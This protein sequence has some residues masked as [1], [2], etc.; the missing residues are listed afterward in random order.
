MHGKINDTPLQIT[1]A[2]FFFLQLCDIVQCWHC[3][4]KLRAWERDNDPWIECGK[5][6]PECQFVL[7]E[8]CAEFIHRLV[9][10]YPDPPCSK[11][12]MLKE[13]IYCNSSI[14]AAPP[15]FLMWRLI[16]FTQS[17]GLILFFFVYYM[18]IYLFGFNDFP[19]LFK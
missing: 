6:F 11:I 1:E 5:W 7:Q 18:R 16:F 2:V 10:L 15:F 4:G 13:I 12:Y 17:Y 3:G 9:K 14:T 19:L 8:I